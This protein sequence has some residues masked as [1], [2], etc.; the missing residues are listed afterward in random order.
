MVNSAAAF[1]MA[2]FLTSILNGLAKP[3]LSIQ[4]DK[5]FVSVVDDSTIT[6]RLAEWLVLFLTLIEFPADTENYA[7]VVHVRFS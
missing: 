2:S 3:I 4:L 7:M 5:S 1:G 6:T